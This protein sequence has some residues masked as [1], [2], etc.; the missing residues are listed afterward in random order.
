GMS[1][2]TAEGT[3]LTVSENGYGKRTETGEYRIQGRG[4]SGVLTMKI[5]DKTGPVVG[6][7]QVL[8]TDDIMIITNSGKI[9]RMHVN[10]ISVMGR[11][12]QGVRLIQMEQGEK[13]VSVAKLAEKDDEE[14]GNGNNGNGNSNSLPPPPPNNDQTGS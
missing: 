8:D 12:T 9:I 10:Q 2:V 5:T 4:G 7:I 6:C 14:N 11:N 1:L 3:L 13:V